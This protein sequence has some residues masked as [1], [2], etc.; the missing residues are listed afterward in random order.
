MLMFCV[1]II[2]ST[3]EENNEAILNYY[4]DY[5]KCINDEIECLG[6]PNLIPPLTVY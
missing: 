2:L 5:V 4:V 6:E 1:Y 3:R